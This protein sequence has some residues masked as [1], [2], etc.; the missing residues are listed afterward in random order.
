MVKYIS[1]LGSTGS[2]GTSALD[3]V[4]AHPEH[5]KIIGLT[6]DHN[7][8]ILEKQIHT[9]HPRIVSV[10]T[11]ELADTL[12]KRISADT[13][14]TYGE[15]GLIEVATHPDSNLVLTSV[16]GVSGLLPTIEALKAKKILPLLTKKH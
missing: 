10:G 11:K 5:F 2:I 4:A 8:D 9:F 6:A 13:K 14:I 7:I 15:D 3:V 1:I 16:V 12:R